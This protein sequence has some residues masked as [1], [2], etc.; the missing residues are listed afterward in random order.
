VRPLYQRFLKALKTRGKERFTLGRTLDSKKLNDNHNKAE[1]EIAG[2]VLVLSTAFLL[3]CAVLSTVTPVLAAVT[4]FFIG[5][6]GVVVFPVL[7]SLFTLGIFFI[8]GY[9]LG[10]PKLYAVCTAIL[11]IF[12]VFTLHLATVMSV[13]NLPVGEHLNNVFFLRVETAEATTSLFTTGGVFFGTFVYAIASVITP[14]ASFVVFGLVMAALAFIM[15]NKRFS[16]IK[17][18]AHKD[19]EKEEARKARAASDFI[20]DPKRPPL[21]PAKKVQQNKLFVDK[22]ISIPSSK[23]QPYDVQMGAASDLPVAPHA[24]VK[25]YS[26]PYSHADTE[27]AAEQELSYEEKRERARERFLSND[28]I[29]HSVPPRIPAIPSSAAS[30]V[31][32]YAGGYDAA[33]EDF[34]KPNGVIG[35]IKNFY[36]QPYSSKSQEAVEIISLDAVTQRIEEENRANEEIKRQESALKQPAQEFKQ[37]YVQEKEPIQMLASVSAA[38]TQPPPQPRRGRISNSE[39]GTKPYGSPPPPP[40]HAMPKNSYLSL[41]PTETQEEKLAYVHKT[42]QSEEAAINAAIENIAPAEMDFSEEKSIDS[43]LPFSRGRLQDTAS[44]HN[45]NV[46]VVELNSQ[47]K[48]RRSFLFSPPPEVDNYVAPEPM[49]IQSFDSEGS[50]EI[51]GEENFNEISPSNRLSDVGNSVEDLSENRGKVNDD[52]SGF[53]VKEDKILP[54]RTPRVKKVSA[55]IGSLTHMERVM[56]ENADKSV[57]PVKCP[58]KIFPRYVRPDPRDHLEGSSPLD[59]DIVENVSAKRDI[60]VDTLK[61]L[62]LPDVVVVDT[63]TGPAVT[64]YELRMPQGIP[65][66]KINNYKEDLE[67]YL[68]VAGKIRIEAPIPGKSLVGVEVPNTIVS[69]VPLRSILESNDFLKSKSPISF[70]LGKSIEN[71]IILCKLEEMPHLLIAGATKS[72]KSVCLNS[73]L[74]SIIYKSSPEDV[75]L[76]LVDPKL[77]EFNAYKGLPH[78]MTGDI[79]TDPKQALAAFDWLKKEMDNRYRILQAAC[80]RDIQE[81][82]NSDAVK[83]GELEKLPYIVLMI[84][85]LAELML[86]PEN[87]KKLEPSIQSVAQKG[88]AAGL[89]LVLATQRPTTDI[90]TGTIKSNLPSRISFFLKSGLDSRVILDEQGAENL[91]GRGDMLYTPM[92]DKPR[93]VQGACVFTPEIQRTMKFVIDNNKKIKEHLAEMDDD[94]VKSINQP[95]EIMME[96]GAAKNGSGDEFDY[97]ANEAMRLIL[98]LNSQNPKV[99]PASASN[100]QRRLSVGYAKAARALDVLEER[101][102]I[103]SLDGSKGREIK[104]TQEQFDQFTN[105]GDREEYDE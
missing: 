22:V 91:I 26:Q 9:K 86:I 10:V 54:P 76:I 30:S 17:T 59:M 51:L 102:W 28:T 27:K 38:P 56:A 92:G 40:M 6:F 105:S 34:K 58:K 80:V 95:E 99:S 85:E 73:I 25:S 8:R 62:G 65:I 13:I 78:I 46:E 84:D 12:L 48:T 36:E 14:A 66:K 16:F 70:A 104:I 71:D 15:L 83:N 96:V 35:I 18:Q 90:V 3:L 77:V 101:G 89:H 72:G 1:H 82:N 32:S 67:C 50:K 60:I 21:P 61:K 79:I 39:V 47:P 69:K 81:Y 7:I 97:F 63:V 31:H 43:P 45:Q 53:Y 24:G 37:E 19:K 57:L 44:S 11:S 20:L 49:P 93:R 75:R 68:E 52:H 94:F 55:G 29:T 103:G 88:R 5:V 4:R 41:T 23:K 98:E 74:M 42:T 64:R 2:W 87:K 100:I 33:Q